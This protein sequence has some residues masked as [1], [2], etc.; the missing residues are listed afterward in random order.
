MVIAQEVFLEEEEYLVMRKMREAPLS[1]LVLLDL[2]R[3]RRF[4]AEEPSVQ[5]EV[6][7]SD[8]LALAAWVVEGAACLGDMEQGSASPKLGAKMSI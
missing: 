4:R 5:N 6:P 2:V 1:V 3:H 7:C 8:N